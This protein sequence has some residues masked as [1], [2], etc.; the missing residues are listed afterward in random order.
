M[1]QAFREAAAQIRQ[2]PVQLTHNQ[3]V[4]AG[5]WWRLYDMRLSIEVEKIRVLQFC[6]VL[7]HYLM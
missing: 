1:N 6:D 3:E 4:R 2:K 7:L 5:I